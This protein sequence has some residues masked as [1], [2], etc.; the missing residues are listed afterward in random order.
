MKDYDYAEIEAYIAEARRL[1]SEVVGEYLSRAWRALK[2]ALTLTGK[3]KA[4]DSGRHGP[5]LPA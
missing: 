4:K 5:Y 3:P 1:R 2:N